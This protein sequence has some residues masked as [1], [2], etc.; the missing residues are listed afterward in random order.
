M[1]KAFIS[2][3]AMTVAAVAV[4]VPPY[5]PL[6]DVSSKTVSSSSSTEVKTKTQSAVSDA[7]S[8]DTP[9][10]EDGISYQPAQED[11][12]NDGARYSGNAN[13]QNYS[14]MQ[15]MQREIQQ[16]RGVVEE[17]NHRLGLMERQA[18]ERYIDLDTRLNELRP[19]SGGGDAVGK[20]PPSDFKFEGDDKALY[21]EASALRQQNRYNDAV[22]AFS[23]LLSRDPD[24]PYAPYCYYWLG[25][26]YMVTSPPQFTVAK[27]NFIQL[28]S[29]HPT[30][31]KVPDAMYKLGKLFAEQGENA[32]AKSTLNELIKKFPDK[33]AAKLGNDLLKTL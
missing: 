30:H 4:A 15:Q 6:P 7:S 9:S 28:L 24:G 26:L 21:T 11:D 1:Q 5:E 33:S 16:L 20:M 8:Q 29:K 23:L 14:Q 25:E 12:G 10:E 32:K 18:R 3:L 13:W 2:V 17:L 27:R 31:V 22:A 19:D